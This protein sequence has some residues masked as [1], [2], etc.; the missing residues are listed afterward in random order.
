MLLIPRCPAVDLLLHCDERDVVDL[1]RWGQ[2]RL[3]DGR[4]RLLQLQRQSLVADPLQVES[5][6]SLRLTGEQAR[7]VLWAVEHN[8]QP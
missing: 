3:V 8:I 6:Q 1:R 2:R 7:F 5:A 4:R